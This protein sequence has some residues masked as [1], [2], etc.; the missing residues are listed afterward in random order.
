MHWL[1]FSEVTPMC[2]EEA[3]VYYDSTLGYNETVGFRSGTTQVFRLPGTS[4]VFELPLHV[5]DTAM[6]YPGRMGVSEP[7]AIALCS[8]LLEKFGKYGGAF[9]VNW[10]DRSL[11][12]ERNWDSAYLA[13][14][15]ELRERKTWFAA[16]GDAVAW[17]EKRRD[18]RFDPAASSS[19]VPIVRMREE[20]GEKG[21]TLAIRVHQPVKY[22]GG[23][24]G[25]R[26]SFVD[27]PVM[28][29]EGIAAGYRA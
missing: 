12:P 27:Y 19:G 8:G 29:G 26:N 1:Y 5:Q 20:N 14:L 4:N 24:Q 22:S 7:Q 11:A 23:V 6:L 21:P 17:F 15:G 18:S 13:L 25:F 16:A 3:G 2:L 9:T 10:H 28:I